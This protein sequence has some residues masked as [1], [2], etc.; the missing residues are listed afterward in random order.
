M[1]GSSSKL[2][3]SELDKYLDKHKLPKC[4]RK[5]DKISTVLCHVMR[6]SPNMTVPANTSSDKE[7]EEGTGSD[8]DVVMAN[9]VSDSDSS[10]SEEET[11]YQVTETRSGR[12]AGTWNRY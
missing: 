11:E 1:S 2:L 5:A 10:D 9:V 4:G 7:E 8:T 6:S 12:K 3:V